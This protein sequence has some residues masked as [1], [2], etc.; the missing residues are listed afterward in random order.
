MHRS[1]AASLALA[2]SVILS[3]CTLSRPNYVTPDVH[4]GEPAFT[5]A[6]EAH[7]VSPVVGGNRA[8]ILVN[9]EQ[10]F[11]AMLAAIRGA[12]TTITFAN[13]IYEDGDIAGRMADALAER[14]RAGVKANVLLDAVGSSG[15]PRRYWR[16]MENAGCTVAWFHSLNPFAIKRINHR[17]HRR[18]LVVDGRIGFT[19]GTG[20]GEQWT[21][22]GRRPD[23]W[24]Q[25]DVRVE[26]PIVLWLQ[27]AFA[28][29][30]RD[31]TGILLGG[32]RYFPSP[33]RRGEIGRAHV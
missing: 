9:G 14:C 3:G 12:R 26:G 4:I 28:E 5:R 6:M 29:N 10:I 7:T 18:I 1:I 2:A 30:W 33:Q 17:N 21:G 23:H 27:A 13:F 15:M 20:V 11:R 25:T 16:E 24:R 32:D 8:E 19:G 31:T 22:D